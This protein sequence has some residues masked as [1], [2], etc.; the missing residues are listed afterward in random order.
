MEEE[1]DYYKLLELQS[2]ATNDEIKKAYK[3]VSRKV[4][5]D[6]NKGDPNAAT[7]FQAVRK[8]YEILSDPK[9]KEAFDNL[10]RAKT[11]RKQRD[12]VMDA[13]RKRMKDDLE[14]R[15][16]ASKK[17]KDDEKEAKKKLKHEIERIKQEGIRRRQEEERIKAEKAA[18]QE[19]EKAKQEFVSF[20]N[21]PAVSLEEHL[22]F[23]QM[24]LQQMMA[25]KS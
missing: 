7:K 4:H 12:S 17:K 15:E 22:D 16:R 10:I 18:A 23:E 19:K 24:I 11:A 6:K 9:A 14:E 20:T 21:G 13:K 2:D 25:N 5:P 1:E 8:A 3:K